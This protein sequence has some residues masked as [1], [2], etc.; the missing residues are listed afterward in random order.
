MAPPVAS[1][2][3][4]QDAWEIRLTRHFLRSD[5]PYGGTPLTHIDATPQE[6]AK[7]VGRPDADP[8][9]VKDDFLSLFRGDTRLREVLSGRRSCR[10]RE[11]REAP[12]YFRHLVLTCLVPAVDDET[13]NEFRERLGSLLG[14]NRRFT[15]SL[16]G[17]AGLWEDLQEWCGRQRKKG[18]PY[19]RLVLPGNG[20]WRLIGYSSRLSFP[21][22]RDRKKLAKLIADKHPDDMRSPG[23]LISAFRHDRLSDRLEG[24]LAAAYDDMCARYE[25]GDRLLG[26]H[27]FWRLAAS[28][29]E[30]CHGATVRRVE[31]TWRIDLLFGLDEDDVEAWLVSDAE[32][33][34]P[35]A[36]GT[37]SEVAA[38]VASD[39]AAYVPVAQAVERRVVAFEERA[40]GRWSSM[41]AMPKG[42]R[43]VTLVAAAAVHPRLGLRSGSW[44]V[45]D[46]SWTISEVLDGDAAA[47]ALRRLGQGTPEIGDDGLASI[48]ILDAVKTG[49]VFLGW[50][51]F[52]PSIR[53]TANS[54]V[55]LHPIGTAS[56]GHP[57]MRS[58]TGSDV[59][60]VVS[61]TPLSGR[62]EVTAVESDVGGGALEASRELVFDDR[63]AIHTSLAEPDERPD[64][65]RPEIEM[66]VEDGEPCPH[67]SQPAPAVDT[68]AVGDPLIGLGEALYAIG[69][70][71]WSEQEFMA[72]CR[73][74]LPADG[75]RAWDVL[76]MLQEAGWIESRLTNRWR[77]RTWYLRPPSFVRI[78]F[79]G[80]D[81]AIVDGALPLGL[82][83]RLEHGVRGVG[84][85]IETIGGGSAWTLPLVMITDVDVSALVD[86]LA[87]PVGGWRAPASAPAPVCWPKER[88]D[89]TN[90]E[91]ASTWDWSRGSFRTE[92]TPTDVPIVLSRWRRRDDSDVFVVETVDGTRQSFGSR[93]P[94][95]VEAHRLAGRQLF[96]RCRDRLLR[97]GGDGFL[98]LPLARA[99]RFSFAVPSGPHPADG[100]RFSYAYPVDDHWEAALLN[101]FG[102]AVGRVAPRD[103]KCDLLTLALS[104]HRPRQRAV[105]DLVNDTID[106]GGYARSH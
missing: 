41:P 12:G 13:S 87:W 84:G 45:L 40:W 23:K 22:W 96:R 39:E 9:A 43:S 32:G 31:P 25:A 106:R 66:L 1:E 91:R 52:L 51:G 21:T 36:R 18:E 14:L 48:R 97:T 92:P 79:G 27:R 54:T 26:G 86:E 34:K 72:L 95:I 73:R 35:V 93:V 10:W 101:L 50:P 80:T 99:L 104:R 56:R 38:R 76:R 68:V 78:P 49:N 20:G 5:G 83:A 8:E 74:V 42:D 65:R 53:A 19:R 105:S 16:A 58:V 30:E 70:A 57:D 59:W 6:L 55:G 24:G 46:G 64:L 63:A 15:G 67:L 82:R 33:A 4:S 44:R 88:R 85:R 90:R 89:H 94:A 28:V 103:S 77:A 98:P 81:R 11:D 2:T 17:I 61:A 62:F 71:G 29:A 7:A 47:R 69:R 60:E 3:P 100:G 75:P 37:F 102:P